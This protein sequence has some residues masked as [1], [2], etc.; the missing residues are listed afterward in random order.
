MSDRFKIC[1]AAHLIM[2][3]DGKILMQRRNNPNKHA[4]GKLGMPAGHLEPNE[5]I[6]DTFKRE[7]KEELNIDV[8]SCEV[9]QVMNLK[10]DTDIYDAYFFTCEYTGEITNMEAENSKSLEW[11]DINSDMEDV[12]PYQKYAIEKYLEGKEKFTV[13]GWE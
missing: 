3:K 13:Y 10:G 11:I 1:C 7:M 5:N 6:Y 4:Y 2:I 9:V 12:M 8:T